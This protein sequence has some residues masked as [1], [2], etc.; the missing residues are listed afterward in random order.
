MAYGAMGENSTALSY[1]EK[2]VAIRQQSLR[3][4]H[5]DLAYSYNNIGNVY[6]SMGNYSEALSSH[7]KALAIRQKSCPP[8][9]SHLAMCYND[10][11]LVSWTAFIAVQ[12]P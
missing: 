3:S 5:P 2:A 4:D 7:E 8:S 1:F 11:G 9:H 10:I 6:Y 12:S